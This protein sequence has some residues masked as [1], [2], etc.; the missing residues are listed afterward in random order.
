MEEEI[1]GKRGAV[2]PHSHPPSP[3][4]LFTLSHRASRGGVQRDSCPGRE[5]GGHTGSG[6]MLFFYYFIEV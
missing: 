2:P 5:W 1:D 3:F 4:T 6:E